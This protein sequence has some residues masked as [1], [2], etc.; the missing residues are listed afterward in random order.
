MY[1]V[2][3]EG[4]DSNHNSSFPGFLIYS[5]PASK[6]ANGNNNNY[7]Q[8]TFLGATRKIAFKFT[9]SVK[10]LPGPVC[11]MNKQFSVSSVSFSAF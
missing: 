2:K 1:L 3:N 11:C 8:K 5:T 6:K 7:W 9:V 10:S 4:M